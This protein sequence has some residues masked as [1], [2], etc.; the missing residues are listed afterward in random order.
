MPDE[1]VADWEHRLDRDGLRILIARLPS[2][3]RRSF[4]QRRGLALLTLNGLV[5]AAVLM[6]P[7]LG[8]LAPPMPDRSLSK[9]DDR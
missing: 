8:A 4:E 3:L 5:A 9:L 2:G 1:R 6:A 7:L